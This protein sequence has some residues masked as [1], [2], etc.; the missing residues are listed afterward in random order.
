[1]GDPADFSDV[2]STDVAP[3]L[4]MMAATDAWPSVRT[5]RSWTLEQLADGMDVGPLA[6][7]G[8]GPG[9]FGHMARA[10]GWATVE[11][12]RSLAMLGALARNHPGTP[13]AAAH[14]WRLPVRAGSLGAARCERVLQW[15][16]DPDAGLGELWRATAPGGWVAVTDTD[17][18]TFTVD[19]PS[20][21]L[22]SVLAEAA[23]GWVP[24]PIFAATLADRL[25]RLGARELRSRVDV[26]ELMAWDPDDPAQRD[27]P[28]GLPLH[29]IAAGAQSDRREAADEAVAAIADAARRGSFAATLSIVTV[30]ARR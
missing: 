28:P 14:L 26:V 24:H 15:T 8:C 10:A 5:A 20:P 29:S 6:D 3:L 12:D 19:A 7:V 18:S 23:L 17:W 16:D 9:T 4:A 1:V 21:D 2:D 11:L 27:G 30:L 22:S 25:G 13:T